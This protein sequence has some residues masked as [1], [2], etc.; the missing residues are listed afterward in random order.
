MSA[1]PKDIGAIL[2]DQL[3]TSLGQRTWRFRTALPAR[4][5]ASEADRMR[6]IAIYRARACECIERAR[7]ARDEGFI[8]AAH[9]YIDEAETWKQFADAWAAGRVPE[10][11]QTPI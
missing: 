1:T 10:D 6:L 3:H 9:G 11:G 5:L 7:L 4:Q 2:P 8:G